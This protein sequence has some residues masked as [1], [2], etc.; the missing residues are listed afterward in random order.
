MS[1]LDVRIQTVP[2]S[3][4][5]GSDFRQCLKSELFGN[6]TIMQMSKIRTFGF[7]TFTV[8][9]IY[10][11]IWNTSITFG[12]MTIQTCTIAKRFRTFVTLEQLFLETKS[13]NLR[14]YRMETK[15]LETANPIS[16]KL[17][18]EYFRL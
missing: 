2:K 16:K 8:T 1:Q 6:G 9:L 3:E 18:C 10:R 12:R 7:Q 11:F 13:F 5:T 17:L 4:Q 15:I 14:N